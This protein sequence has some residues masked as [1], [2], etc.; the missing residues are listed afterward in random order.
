MSDYYI[1]YLLFQGFRCFRNAEINPINGVNILTGADDVGKSTV[2]YGTALLLSRDTS[3][4]LMDTD[5]HGLNVE[6]EFQISATITC[7]NKDSNSSKK[8]TISVKGTKDFKLEFSEPESKSL[9]NSEVMSN[10]EMKEILDKLSK[11]RVLDNGITGQESFMKSGAENNSPTNSEQEQVQ[12]SKSPLLNTIVTTPISNQPVPVEKLQAALTNNARPNLSIESSVE[13]VDRTKLAE[14]KLTEALTGVAIPMSNWGGGTKVATHQLHAGFSQVLGSICLI[15]E[16]A[17]NVDSLAQRIMLDNLSKLGGQAFVVATSP[18]ILKSSATHAIIVVSSNDRIGKVEGDRVDQLITSQPNA[19]FAKKIIIGEGATEVGF[20]FG[21][22]SMVLGK[23]PEYFGLYM[24]DG[25]GCNSALTLSKQWNK[26]GQVAGI[27]IDKEG[28]LD[29]VSLEKLKGWLGDLFFQWKKGNLESNYIWAVPIEH[30]EK[31]IA[32]P[33]IGPNQRLRT[34]ADRIGFPTNKELN[35]ENL[36]DFIGNMPELQGIDKSHKEAMIYKKF[37]QVMVEAALGIA[38]EGTSVEKIGD[39][40]GHRSHWFK[41]LSGG[42]E[43]A[44][45]LDS[46]GVWKNGLHEPLL[47]FVNAYRAELGLPK[48]QDLPRFTH[49]IDE[50]IA[51][52]LNWIN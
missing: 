39:F 8:F 49:S 26:D 21:L 16:F 18:A 51:A 35:L 45:K 43:L 4:V 48:I 9:S 42:F 34:I 29:Q 50:A 23:P 19:F 40:K 22:S 11:T 25:E 30:L 15:D 37:Y 10:S 1:S 52:G 20:H 28:D 24:C 47:P 38:P 17:I 5:Y 31:F 7:V 33:E 41:S 27:F 2:L 14:L 3:I 44:L 13:M 12:P 46:C 32:N 6:G 36:L